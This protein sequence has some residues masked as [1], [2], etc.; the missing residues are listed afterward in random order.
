MKKIIGFF[1]LVV[2]LLCLTKAISAETDIFVPYRGVLFADTFETVG[3]NKEVTNIFQN[4]ANL[5]G[6]IRHQV[7][8]DSSQ[9]FFGYNHVVAGYLIPTD[10]FV[11]GIGMNSFYT[12]DI[13]RVVD[14]Q[15]GRPYISEYFGHMNRVLSLVLG[16]PLKAGFQAGV[17]VQNYLQR[18][19]TDEA[20]S[21]A[22]DFGLSWKSDSFWIGTYSRNLLKTAY[23]WKLSGHEESLARKVVVE[24][25]YYNDFFQAK[26]ANDS[27]F[28]RGVVEFYLNPNF[29]FLGDG[30]WKGEL[31]RYSY[32]VCIDF[33]IFA[34]QYNHIVYVNEILSLDRDLIGVVFSFGEPVK[35]PDIRKF[36]Q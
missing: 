26:I 31:Q 33:D 7:K 35:I 25:G 8:I 36:E 20:S 5:A 16:V 21:Y 11:L 2:I 23:K 9:N 13:P 10:Y 17:Q 6:A 28:S 30:V 29:S 1:R 3:R 22:V 32:G 19:D 14:S 24:G 4:P 34:L 12:S 18:L 15:I 27:T